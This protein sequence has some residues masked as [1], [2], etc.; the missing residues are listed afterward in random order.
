MKA[1]FGHEEGD[2]TTQVALENSQGRSATL[3][4]IYIVSTNMEQAQNV[5]WC[6]SEI[7]C[8]VY[9]MQPDDFF[10]ADQGRYET[11]GIDR[12]ACMRAAG[13]MVGFPALVIDGG[14][15]MTYTA[16]DHKGHIVGGGKYS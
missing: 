1:I 10:S 4:T 5:A 8:R 2:M 9:T 11:M 6:F 3:L 16:C 13:E 12:L 15:C 7:P 14:T